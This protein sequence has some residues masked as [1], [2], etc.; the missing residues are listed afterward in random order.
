MELATIIGAVISV[1]GALVTVALTSIAFSLQT[2]RELRECYIDI[3][4]YRT[5]H[6]QVLR[7]A[8]E[9]TPE[10]WTTIYSKDEALQSEWVEYYTYLEFCL[11]YCAHLLWTRG[12]IGSHYRKQSEP[13]V[14]LMITENWPAIQDLL[15]DEYANPRVRSY[16]LRLQASGRNWAERHRSLALP[17]DSRTPL[18]GPRNPT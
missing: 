13:L 8:R 3:M 5:E 9:F 7:R 11:I 17:V 2:R 4:R 18:T 15:K 14:R 12:I 6:P 10:I 16:V 1:A